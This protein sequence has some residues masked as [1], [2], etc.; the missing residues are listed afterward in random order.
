MGISNTFHQ[1]P[2]IVSAINGWLMT[3]PKTKA[4]ISNLWIRFL[5]HIGV[6]TLFVDKLIG[7]ADDGGKIKLN[8]VE[9][10]ILPAHFLHS[11][12][13]FQVYDP[14][15]KILYSGD[16]GASL[17]QDYIFVEDFEN[18]IQYMSGLHKRY[19]SSKVAINK[20]VNMVKTL[21]IDIIAP[22]HGVFIKGKDN[23]ERFYSWLES[24]ELDI[25][26]MSYMLPESYIVV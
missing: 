7:I 16:L 12:G 18:H 19:L 20:W 1:D 4:L 14:V 6:D 10:L 25:D 11:P 23:I 9:L 15:S 8:Q 13:N 2:D 3:L 17:G 24:I 26:K 21:D 5:P 22:Q